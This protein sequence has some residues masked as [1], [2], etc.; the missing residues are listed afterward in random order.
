MR[1]SVPM[2]QQE[3][4]QVFS[5]LKWIVTIT[6]T[7]LKIYHDNHFPVISESS[8]GQGCTTHASGNSKCA[9]YSVMKYD[10]APVLRGGT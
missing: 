4:L 6:S 2:S 7:S 3:P 10:G 1:N 5:G 9:S 8:P